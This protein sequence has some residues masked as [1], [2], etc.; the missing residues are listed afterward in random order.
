MPIS[1]TTEREARPTPVVMDHET[2]L[3]YVIMLT[4]GDATHRH[5]KTQTSPFST[6]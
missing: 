3:K 4:N 5:N 1:L 6:S 2:H